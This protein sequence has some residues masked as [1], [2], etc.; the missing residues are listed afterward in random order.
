M[1]IDLQMLAHRLKHII[2]NPVKAWEIIKRENRSTGTVHI[3]FLMPLLILISLSAFAGSLIYN[4]SGLS[5]LYPIILAL[6]QFLC[7]YLTV[8]ISSWILNELSVAFVSKKDYS[9]N[10][11]LIVYSLSPLY[12]T[13]LVTRF[14]PDLSILNILGFYGAYIMYSG[15]NTIENLAGKSLLRY[16]IIALLTVMI[17]YLTI[18]WITRSLLE[19]IYF[20]FAGSI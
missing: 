15:L 17:S 9:F 18:S 10:F 20:A 14:L 7:F 11:K 1:M 19:G 16:F 5:V 3:S 8:L 13:V 2:V 4:P 6:K 12:L